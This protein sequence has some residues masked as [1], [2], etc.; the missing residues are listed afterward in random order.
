MSRQQTQKV[1]TIVITTVATLVVIPVLLIILTI[2]YNGL[3][4][5]SWEF[6]TQPPRNGM[7]EGG[8][9][10]AILGT[11]LLT[12]GTAVAAI[13]QFHFHFNRWIPTGIQYFPRV[14]RFYVTHDHSFFISCRWLVAD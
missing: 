1:A 11:I 3:S 9:M 6:L 13:K 7:T 14:N 12:L 2:F 4:A 10:P 5:I 8:I